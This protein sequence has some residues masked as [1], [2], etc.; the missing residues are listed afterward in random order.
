MACGAFPY[1]QNGGERWG[2]QTCRTSIAKKLEKID[3][4]DVEDGLYNDPGRFIKEYPYSIIIQDEDCL[5]ATIEMKSV[6]Q[7]TSEAVS[8]SEA[9]EVVKITATSTPDWCKTE[10]G[11]YG[12]RQ[13]N[14]KTAVFA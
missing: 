3:K 1:D 12:R 14:R 10:N 13:N 4:K 9:Q 2:Y 7:E 11:F 8:L 6:A 5:D